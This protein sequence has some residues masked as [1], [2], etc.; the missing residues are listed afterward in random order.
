MQS[1]SLADPI[2]EL[3]Q[4]PLVWW[5]RLL[6]GLA[7]VLTAGFA[8]FLWGNGYLRPQPDCCGNGGGSADMALTPDGEA[9]TI[10]AFLFN[11]SGRRLRVSSA[12][13][14]LPGATVLNIT[15]L[16]ENEVSLFPI[17]NTAVRELPATI[18]GGSTRRLVITFV[19]TRCDDDIG[20]WGTAKVRLDVV[21]VWWPTFGRTFTVPNPI[22]DSRRSQLSVFPPEGVDPSTL[23]TPLASACA[24]LGV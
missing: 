14:D 15:I 9:V 10:T 1:L 16:D 3:I 11:S 21:G 4:P 22:V 13:V 19:P 2:D 20:P 24:L 8:S 5:A 18:A 6:V 23:K 12:T 7:V 17:P